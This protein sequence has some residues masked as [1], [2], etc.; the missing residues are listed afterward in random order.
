ME[1]QV[2]FA[3]PV[4]YQEPK[5]EPMETTDCS[6]DDGDEKERLEKLIDE[7]QTTTEFIVS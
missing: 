5:V 1:P 2:D 7:N 4:G 6:N 3:A